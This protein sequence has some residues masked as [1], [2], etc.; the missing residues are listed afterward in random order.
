MKRLVMLVLTILVFF[1]TLGG[2][3][4]VASGQTAVEQ[5]SKLQ[6]EVPQF[7]TEVTNYFGD[8]VSIWDH[9]QDGW[10]DFWCML[11]RD[12][13]HRDKHTDTD[14]DGVTDYDEMI[15]HRDPMVPGPI[16]RK[17]TPEEQK[18]QD[19]LNEKSRAE[20]HAKEVIRWRE[21]LEA[22]APYILTS[23]TKKKHEEEQAEKRVEFLKDAKERPVFVEPGHD[24]SQ[25]LNQINT[26]NGNRSISP[27]DYDLTGTGVTVALMEET[28]APANHP[29]VGPITIKPTGVTPIYSDHTMSVACVLASRGTVRAQGRGVSPSVALWSYQINYAMSAQNR[30]IQ[31]ATEGS[32]ISNHSYGPAYG[33]VGSYENHDNQGL[34]Q[35][36]NGN[37]SVSMD[38]PNYAGQYREPVRAMDAASHLYPAHLMVAVTGNSRG[39][40]SSF[41]PPNPEDPEDKTKKFYSRDN[42]GQWVLQTFA[43]TQALPKAAGGNDGGF[44]SLTSYGAAKNPIVVGGINSN[45]SPWNKSGWGPTDDGRIKPDLVAQSSQVTASYYGGGTTPKYYDWWEGTSYAAPVVSGTAALITQAMARPVASDVLK[46]IMIHTATDIDLVGPDC[47][48]GYGNLNIDGAVELVQANAL[49]QSSPFIKRII[50]QNGQISRIKVKVK[51]DTSPFIKATLVWNDPPASV[52][53]GLDVTC[54]VLNKMLVNDL[55]LYVLKPGAVPNEIERPYV[56]N[57]AGPSFPA[58]RGVNTLDNVEQV[59]IN[60]AVSDGVYTIIVDATKMNSSSAQGV[61]VVFSGNIAEYEEEKV[62]KTTELLKVGENEYSLGWQSRAGE[63]YTIQETTTL[64]VWNDV[65]SGIQA[66]GDDSYYIVPSSGDKK[67]WRVVEE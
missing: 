7:R 16:P 46:A 40:G 61:A 60:N 3:I 64:G 17:L 39:V 6:K 8:K 27:F 22:R 57:P 31:L 29:E 34:H 58:L 32:T 2:Q 55:D 59:Y 23:E 24:K 35:T 48:T 4:G 41:F 11:F 5:S 18:A 21:D 53:P 66:I 10:E 19:V 49:L 9:D 47:R 51:P 54:D 30:Y 42:A 62:I 38:E 26:S 52:I 37:I 1:G 45:L 20:N 14:E 12:I 63:S 33:W 25:S 43:E 36:Y 44:D 15:L 67:F 13:K 65:A 50:V 28:V 56:L